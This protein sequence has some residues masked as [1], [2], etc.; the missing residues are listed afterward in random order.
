M[1]PRFVFLATRFRLPLLALIHGATGTSGQA[2][3]FNQ[4]YTWD[5]SEGNSW[6]QAKN[7]KQTP[8]SGGTPDNANHSVLFPNNVNRG[9]VDLKGDNQRVGEFNIEVNSR[10]Y[11]FNSGRLINHGNLNI[12]ATGDTI[13]FGGGLTWE[14]AVAGTWTN[15]GADL[16]FKGKIANI[17]SNTPGADITMAGDITF[18]Q[19]HTYEGTF[20]IASGTTDISAVPD[21]FQFATLGISGTGG[22]NTGGTDFKIGGFSGNGSLNL[23]GRTVNS[24]SMNW[25]RTFSGTL[26]GTEGDGSLFVHDGT[27]SQTFSGSMSGLDA[28]E[29]REGDL[30]FVGGD[31]QLVDRT[32]DGG[33]RLTGGDATI[34][35]GAAVTLESSFVAGGNADIGD[36]T[37]TIDGGQ[38][39]AARIFSEGGGKIRLS[40][41]NGN[42][43]LVIGKSGSN[44]FSYISLL[45]DLSVRLP[46]PSDG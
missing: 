40:D 45:A 18:T 7:W 5:G 29:A 6:N 23:A 20:G 34:S 44:G 15:N 43:A 36:R 13:E 37:L 31:F 22:L 14:Q 9:F 16:L 28:V 24:G 46:M 25:D 8:G 11:T 27:G 42:P 32:A 39:K 3:T 21:A 1:K 17:D 41:A 30:L 2:Q 12:T 35:S 10:G 38:L 33:L 4:Y 26:S 19:D